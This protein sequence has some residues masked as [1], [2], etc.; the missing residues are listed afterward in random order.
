MAVD[1][2]YEDKK[3]AQAMAKHLREIADR[4]ERMGLYD[5]SLDTEDKADFR[6]GEE[7]DMRTYTH[8]TIDLKIK[9]KP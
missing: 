7:I 6:K 9:R 5:A 4:V 3:I 2:M 8:V 1:V